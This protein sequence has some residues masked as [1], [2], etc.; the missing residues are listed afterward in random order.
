MRAVSS[1]WARRARDGAPGEEFLHRFLFNLSG[2]ERISQ[3]F[4]VDDE[5][6][7]HGGSGLLSARHQGAA[8][9]GGDDVLGDAADEG[10]GQQTAHPGI[11]NDQVDGGAFGQVLQ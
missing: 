10:L 1:G 5:P 4:R 6:G 2:E 7:G 3:I 9:E 11:E 8:G